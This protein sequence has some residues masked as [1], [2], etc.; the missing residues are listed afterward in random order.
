MDAVIVLAAS[1]S[2]EVARLIQERHGQRYAVAVLRETD[3]MVI[4]PGKTNP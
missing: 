3:L 2:D 1:Y 4:N